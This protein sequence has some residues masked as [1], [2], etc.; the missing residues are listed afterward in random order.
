MD[1]T[2]TLLSKV[3]INI[4][5][6]SADKIGVDCSSVKYRC[7]K[8]DKE[9]GEYVIG[10]NKRLHF[11]K[12]TFSTASE[13][14][15]L[16]KGVFWN[17][18]K[19]LKLEKEELI[20]STFSGKMKAT[21]FVLGDKVDAEIE[22]DLEFK[23]GV[24]LNHTATV[25]EKDNSERKEQTEKVKQAVI[26]KMKKESTFSYKLIKLVVKNP[27]LFVVHSINYIL[28]FVYD[29]FVSIERKIN[30]I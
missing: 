9:H 17:G 25:N 1:K 12:R 22:L 6:K 8:F 27:L 5:K 11:L 30:K 18:N 13:D 23:S 14:D 7:G 3:K 15:V 4:P 28:S 16:K 26:N 24:L 19:Y 29:F 20:P 21:T 10:N 2:S